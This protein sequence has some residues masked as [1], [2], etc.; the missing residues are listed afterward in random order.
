MAAVSLTGARR[1][2][3][4]VL[5]LFVVARF[6]GPYLGADFWAFQHWAHTSTLF[7]VAWLILFV[8]LTWLAWSG[9]D[10]I[11]NWF[12][13]PV[14][15]I[16]PLV[17]LVTLFWLFRFDTFLYGGGN[18]Q[19]GRIA[20]LEQVGGVVI[21]RWYEFGATALAHWLYLGLRAIGLGA[22]AWRLLTYVSTLLSLLASVQIAR[23]ISPDRVRRV[24][25]FLIVFFGGQALLYFGYIGIAPIAVPVALWFAYLVC[26]IERNASRL[27]PVVWL[28]S[29]QLLGIL[30]HVSLVYLLPATIYVTVASVIDTPRARRLGVIA[31]GITFFVLLAV[32]YLQAGQSMALGQRI[33]FLE[34]KPP[35]YD[36]GLMSLRRLGDLLQLLFMTVPTVVVALWLYF[37]YARTPASP[38]VVT[39]AGFMS[40]G[41]LAA[42]ALFDPTNG[43]V[44]DLPRLLAYLT[45]FGFLIAVIFNGLDAPTGA[46]KRLQL[47]PLTAAAAVMLPVSYLPA[48]I[49]V[50]MADPYVDSYLAEHDG[51]YKHACFAFRD[52][53]FYVEDY[54]KATTWEQAA[55]SKSPDRINLTGSAYLMA[56]NDHSEA[57]RT[58]SQMISR[59]RYWAEPRSLL[60]RSYMAQGRYAAA[61][62][63]IDTALMLEPY[64]R[65][66]YI[67]AYECYRDMQRFDLALEK[68]HEALALYPGDTFMVTDLMLVNFRAQNYQTADSIATALLADNPTHAYGYFV[69]GALADQAGNVVIARRNYQRFLELAGDN[70]DVPAVQHRLRQLTEGTSQ[71]SPAPSQ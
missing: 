24:F 52:A 58:L 46:G 41:G 21:Y 25:T 4:V 66:H 11:G 33:L 60:A 42:M 20:K 1:L 45:P 49:D 62:P 48:Y 15:V 32:L 16:V 23:L 64:A 43:I 44:L 27:T 31:G 37:R 2:L 57:I 65:Q 29:L 17:V 13:T 36:Y 61:L 5:G 12:R 71:G 40:L 22:N 35:F 19:V 55:E 6:V 70:P 10:R 50:E 9:Q 56:G 38:R 26:R 30:L 14:S 18:I 67:N 3:I 69:K 51:Y 54:D 7:E 47:L 28:W 68:I 34:G 59:D 63:Q 39:A 8:A 53:Y